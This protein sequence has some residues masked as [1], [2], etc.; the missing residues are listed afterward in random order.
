MKCLLEDRNFV[1][2]CICMI[3]LKYGIVGIGYGK[4]KILLVFDCYVLW[5]FFEC[6]YE[7]M[8]DIFYFVLER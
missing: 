1:F 3:F 7:W 4:F 5:F 8:Y 6:I 2:I